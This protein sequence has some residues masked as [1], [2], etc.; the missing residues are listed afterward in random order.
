MEE[1]SYV[2]IFASKGLE[3]MVVLAYFILFV[4]FTRALAPKKKGGDKKPGR[5]DHA[6]R[7]NQGRV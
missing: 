1:Y 3:Y 6:D 2:D 7:N 4:Y 5:K